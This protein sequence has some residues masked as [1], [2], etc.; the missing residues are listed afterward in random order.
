MAPLEI[1]ENLWRQLFQ[2]G[3]RVLSQSSIYSQVELIKEGFA[4]ITG[5]HIDIFLLDCFKPLPSQV[6]HDSMTG[7]DTVKFLP[8]FDLRPQEVFPSG[9]ISDYSIDLEKDSSI[10]GVLE[11]HFDQP[12]EF[13]DEFRQY[14]ETAGIY[15]AGILD[16]KRMEAIKDLRSE[17]LALVRSVNYEIA[18]YRDAREL[19]SKIVQLIQAAFNFYFVGIYQFGEE[20]KMLNLQASAGIELSDA[21]HQARKFSHRIFVRMPITAR[22]RAWLE[23]GRK[24]ACLLKTANNSWES[25]K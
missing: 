10:L 23:H 19:L 8:E 1:N 4:S 2:M 24:S 15:L 21:L 12:V 14:L 13:S 3:N 22:Y 11:F 17:Q 6:N 16:M 18:S 20:R 25:L 7:I 5:A 9:G